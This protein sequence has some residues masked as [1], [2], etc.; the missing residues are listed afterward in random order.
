MYYGK[1]LGVNLVVNGLSDLFW[2][3]FLLPRTE[4]FRSSVEE[5]W[6]GQSVLYQEF[7]RNFR[8]VSHS[9]PVYSMGRWEHVNR[10]H[11]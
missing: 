10:H 11:H 1:S 3:V 7:L 8:Q 2:S 4:P 5:I 6:R 9:A